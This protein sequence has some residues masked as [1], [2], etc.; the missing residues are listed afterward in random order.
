ME[1]L[2]T[3]TNNLGKYVRIIGH[4]LV[5]YF[6]TP[7]EPKLRKWLLSHPAYTQPRVTKEQYETLQN[8]LQHT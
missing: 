6:N 4:N 3:H 8:S 7:N 2:T 5:V 1:L